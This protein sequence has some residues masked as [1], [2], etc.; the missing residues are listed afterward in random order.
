[1]SQDKK[2]IASIMKE[3]QMLEWQVRKL[4]N[5]SLNYSEKELLSNIKKLAQLDFGLKTGT[6]NKESA[7]DS[8]FISLMV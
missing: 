3:M 4:Y 6:I 2:D 1:M 8:F 5:E 7:M